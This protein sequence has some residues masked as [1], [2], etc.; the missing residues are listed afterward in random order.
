MTMR[1]PAVDLGVRRRRM[2][3]ESRKKGQIGRVLESAWKRKA[4][5]TSKARCVTFLKNLSSKFCVAKVCYP[6]SHIFCRIDKSMLASAADPSKPIFN[7][8]IGDTINKNRL[9]DVTFLC[10]QGF[11]WHLTQTA[12]RIF[13]LRLNDDVFSRQY[14]LGNFLNTSWLHLAV[15]AQ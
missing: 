11:Y 14:F 3:S 1:P 9:Q 6:S 8:S 5:F 13:D 2:H 10:S 4:F 12:F 15:Q 7:K